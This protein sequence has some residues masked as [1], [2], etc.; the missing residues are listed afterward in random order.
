MKRYQFDLT[1]AGA[2]LLLEGQGE[3]VAEAFE[4]ALSECKDALDPTE[5]EGEVIW[6]PAADDDGEEMPPIVDWFNPGEA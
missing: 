4:N 1:C 5:I 6:E 3:T 2:H